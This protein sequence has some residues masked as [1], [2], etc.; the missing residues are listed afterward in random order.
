MSRLPA[1]ELKSFARVA[2][3]LLVDPPV[4]ATGSRGQRGRPGVGLEYFDHRYYEPGDELRHIDWRQSAR[5]GAAVVRRYQVETS[6]EWILC[7]DASSSMCGGDGAKWRLASACATALA[8]AF[9]DMGHRVGMLLF[10]DEVVAACP[11]G[12]GVAH[13]P[14]L[15]RTLAEHVPARHGARSRLGSCIDRLA[16]RPCAFVL[17]DFLTA[18]QMRRDLAGLQARCLQL[19][20]LR[21]ASTGDATLPIAGHVTLVDRETGERVDGIVDARL[22]R[23]ARAAEA[24]MERDLRVFCRAASVPFSACEATRDWRSALVAHL[25]ATHRP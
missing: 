17:G 6:S 20:V 23:A 25:R 14:R 10:S 19:Q 3:H 13:Y 11:L 21:I 22:E 7:L 1:A 12:R 18:D 4:R 5:R 15:L 2:A 9:L 16:G 24:A 8:Y